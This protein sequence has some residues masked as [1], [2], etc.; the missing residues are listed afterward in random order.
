MTVE[1]KHCG[2]DGVWRY[3]ELYGFPVFDEAGRVTQ[4]IEISMDI[5]RRKELEAQLL[6]ISNTDQLTGLH[7]RRGFL[8]MAEQQLQVAQ[9]T[10]TRL[11]LLFFDLDNFKQINDSLGHE[12]GDTTLK[13]AASVLKDTLRQA[14]II[15][16][17]GGDE[18]AAVLVEGGEATDDAMVHQRLR[19]NLERQNRTLPAA[20]PLELSYGIAHFDPERP[21]TLSELIAVADQ[22]MYQAKQGKKASRSP[23]SATEPATESTPEQPH[24]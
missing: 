5:T 17:L 12:N 16:R 21:C 22:H 10:G 1:H 8:A 9:R 24:P 13:A 23:K 20:F 6:E 11:A 14:D 19:E 7:N 18:F 2:H 4:M 3:Y 15:G